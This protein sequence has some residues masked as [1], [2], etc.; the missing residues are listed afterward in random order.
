MTVRQRNYLFWK[1]FLGCVGVLSFVWFISTIGMSVV[2][3]HSESE[4]NVFPG[5]EEL[6]N[7]LGE[8]NRLEKQNSELKKLADELR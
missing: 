7:V 8:L 5:D 1:R 4:N 3:Y 2:V 6:T